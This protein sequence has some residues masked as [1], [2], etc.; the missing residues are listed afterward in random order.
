MGNTRAWPVLRTTDLGEA[1]D[2]AERLLAVA[3]WYDPAGCYL[4]A[5]A[6][7]HDALDR[8]VGAFPEAKV[9]PWLEDA[10]EFVA[11]VSLGVK[12]VVEARDALVAWADITRCYVLWHNLKWPALPE[13]GLEY[14]EY[15]YAE[16]QIASNS[17]DIYCTEWTAE[18]TVFVHGRP[19]DEARPAW[20][21][22]QVGAGIVGPPEFGW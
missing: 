14:E 11:S 5:W 18:H 21:A 3:S 10:G 9:E 13:L 4:D 16:L 19:G 17:H 1:L 7:T 6:Y 2:L 20:L 12:S 8:L 15:K 22:A